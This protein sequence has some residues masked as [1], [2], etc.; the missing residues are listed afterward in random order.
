MEV[1]V[2]AA[3]EEAAAAVAVVVTIVP[4]DAVLIEEAPASEVAILVV[5]AVGEERGDPQGRSSS[6]RKLPARRLCRANSQLTI[7]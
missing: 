3:V 7:H 1:A 4:V 2:E 6:I 5:A